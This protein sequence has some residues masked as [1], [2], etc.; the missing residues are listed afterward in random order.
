MQNL[1][2]SNEATQTMLNNY[3]TLSNLNTTTNQIYVFIHDSDL[4]LNNYITL[5]NLPTDFKSGVGTYETLEHLAIRTS[6][7]NYVTRAV[8]LVT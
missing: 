6:D 1:D 7:H 2:Q 5:S 4:A 3:I 8:I